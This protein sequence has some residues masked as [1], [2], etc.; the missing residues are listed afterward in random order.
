MTCQRVQFLTPPR[1]L[2]TPVTKVWDI[3]MYLAH[4]KCLTVTM[5]QTG[6]TSRMNNHTGI[7]VRAMTE[8]TNHEYGEREATRTCLACP[9]A[10][11]GGLFVNGCNNL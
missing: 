6:I 5:I 2:S 1:N 8:S 9:T 10:L 11:V 4:L 7:W 3:D